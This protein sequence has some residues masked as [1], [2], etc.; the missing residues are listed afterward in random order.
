MSRV[1]E[2][3]K[4][5]RQESKMPAKVVAKKL[6][7]SEGNLLEIESGK[8]VINEALIA[9][10][11]K[12]LNKDINAMGLSSFETDSLKE[13]AR[14]RAESLKKE[15]EKKTIKTNAPAMKKE[16]N[17]I[18]DQAFGNNLKSVSVM[19]MDLKSKKASNVY[20][21]SN[22]KID[23][24]NADKVFSFS[25]DKDDLINYGILKNSIVLAVQAKEI[26]IEGFYIFEFEGSNQL[27]KCRNLGNG[28]ILTIK[29]SGEE[30]S[31][32]ISIKDMK[33]IGQAFK[34]INEL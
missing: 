16:V 25:Y 28:N 8:K 23:A 3:I 1:G 14:E 22:G 32:T 7:I 15:R 13:D 26:I 34:V 9:R 17:E 20:P 31:R 29:N 2:N 24:H 18:W 19:A 4:K 27:R 21:V 12:V 30:I 6:G 5:A 11:S 33:V 10:V